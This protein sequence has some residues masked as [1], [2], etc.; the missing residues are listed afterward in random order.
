MTTLLSFP[1]AI[2]RAADCAQF[3]AQLPENFLRVDIPAP[4]AVGKDFDPIVPLS[5]GKYAWHTAR[6]Q[7]GL[8][9]G[10]AQI[11]TDIGGVRIEQRDALG[12]FADTATLRLA[13][14]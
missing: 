11:T 8:P 9:A 6:G 14:P 5:R 3:V 1:S 2:A 12:V 10:S 4:P 13:G 7:A